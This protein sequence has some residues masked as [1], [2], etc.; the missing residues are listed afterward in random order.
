MRRLE[1]LHLVIATALAG[2]LT[3][4]GVAAH[5]VSVQGL[6]GERQILVAAVFGTMV[7][8]S[9][10]R[11]L[12]IY[13]ADQSEAVHI[14]EGILV[15]M[16]VLVRPSVVIM[17]FALATLVSQG[18]MRRPLVKSAFNLGQ[19]LVAVGLAEVVFVASHHSS[20]PT[21]YAEAGAA[22]LAVTAFFLA[23]S[24]AITLVL[25]A[26]GVPWKSVVLNGLDMRLA[27][28]FG[29]LGI[30]YGCA[31]LLSAEPAAL[32]L[33]VLPLIILRCSLGGFFRARR[34]RARL[35]GLFRATL[36]ANVSMGQEQRDVEAGLLRSA[37]VLLRCREASLSPEPLERQALRAAVPLLGETLWLSVAGRSRT[38][39]FDSTDKTLLEALAAVAAGALSNTTLYH[40]SERQKRRLAAI[41]SSLGEGVCAL[42]ASG[43]VTYMNKAAASMLG[44]ETIG[45]LDSDELFAGPDAGAPAPDFLWAAARRALTSGTTSTSYDARFRRADGG[46]VDVACTVAPNVEDGEPNGAVLVFRDISEHKR[47]A[48]LAHQAFHD[49]LTGLPNRRQFLHDLYDALEVSRQTGDQHAVLFLDIDRFKV[50]NDSLGHDAGD[51]L[52]IAI[53]E[54]VKDVVR[55]GDT[56]ARLGGDE[57]TVLLEHVQGVEEAT[58]IAQR[59]LDKMR[60]P[61]VLPDGHHVLPRLSIGI[62]LTSDGKD[63]D[64]ILRDA[65]VAMYQAKAKGGGGGYCVF[66]SEV[67]GAR[68]SERV[69]IEME[70]RQAIDRGELEVYYQP[71]F[72]VL[73]R[74]VVSV[75][76]LVRWHHPTRGILA[77]EAFID[78]AEETGL[79]L[80]LGREVLEQ[81]CH[82]VREWRERLGVA[83]KVAINLSARQFEHPQLL[84]EVEALLH[85][86]GTDAGQFCFEVTESLAVND[87][88]RTNE[89]LWS[90][91]SLGAS[92]A[93]DDFGT[94]HSALDHLAEFPIDVVKIDR[95]FISNV[96]SDPVKSAIVS[97]VL[98]MA[99]A[100][101]ST[102]VVEGVETEPE[103]WHLLDL[104]C[105]VAQGF[106]F[107]HPLPASQVEAF[108]APGG[109]AEVQGP[110]PDLRLPGPEQPVNPSHSEVASAAAR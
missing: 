84:N 95:A 34:D 22:A 2:G 82:Q 41:T 77:P 75:E 106:L 32:P 16:L 5:E 72:S 57:F 17:T 39:P 89:I 54:R 38:E 49:P 83:V 47:L 78:V 87:V 91:K 70:L 109:R 93:I 67:M 35:E 86:A 56:L 65:D 3:V 21:T 59:I 96:E 52:L 6:P 44:W 88:R 45:G 58:E 28:A 9:W 29:G 107:S 104:G 36:E 31:L 7:L 103:L 8:L 23:S 25:A 71:L 94:G 80:E 27:I 74:Q 85:A 50:V 69:E 10:L 68:S 55:D 99:K 19:M 48:D 79:I 101:G 53:T 13:V 81:V 1:R 100:I 66:D 40:H 97:A 15:V 30:G 61:V 12:I 76:A 24:A 73:D 51:L 64:D 37:R 43:R 92:V 18:L 42:S 14:D 33:A 11:P 26:T 46:I 60:E 110:P 105:S 4:L 90:L 98:A 108:L 63:H 102:T 20:A 62:A